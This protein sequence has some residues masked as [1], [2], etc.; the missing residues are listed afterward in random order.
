MHKTLLILRYEIY[1]LVSRPSFWIGVFAAPLVGLLLLAGATY[2]KNSQGGAEI[3]PLAQVGELLV[4]EED[5]RPQGYVD[6]AGLVRQFP[7]DFPRT[8][9]ISY[10]DEGAARRALDE[11]AIS[12]YYVIDR[13]YITS[14]SLAAY[15]A[16]FNLSAAEER[17]AWLVELIDF[18]LLGGDETLARAVSAPFIEIKKE[19]LA[20]P[21]TARARDNLLSFVLPYAMMTLFFISIMGSSSLMLNGLAKEKE[22]RVMEVLVN[23]AS[24]RELL[25]GKI[26]GL[27]LVGLFQVAIWGV[28]A[29]A[30]LRISGQV[31]SLPAGV[32]LPASVLGWGAAF[33]VLGYLLY[34]ALMAGL[35]AL[36]PGLREASQATFL[37]TLPLMAPFFLITALINAP[38][39]GLAVFFSLFPFSA[40]MGMMLRLSATDVPL[41]QVL[42][43]L[44]LLA[45]TA[46]VVIRATAGL[47]RAQTLLSGQKLTVRNVVKALRGV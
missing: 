24:P 39:G 41:W 42:L 6:P 43:S 8:D 40:P 17:S 31:F 15:S 44:A 21:G 1:S 9:W 29:F 46:L 7:V 30:L 5:P 14:G 11:G 35:G 47:F 23:S 2:L 20:P 26:S 45:L 16:D 10:P 4:P 34:A 38:N 22:T 18:N 28:S 12:T 37:I 33:F 36:A 25:L 19:S 3:D 27:G 13:D 32:E